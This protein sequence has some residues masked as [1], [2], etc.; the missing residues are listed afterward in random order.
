[1]YEVSYYTTIISM[2]I[3]LRLRVMTWSVCGF[4]K[5]HFQHVN[6]QQL[7][8]FLK[9]SIIVC[10]NNKLIFPLKILYI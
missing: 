5:I 9:V 7:V 10:K 8:L 6:N 2:Y 4:K 1:M 3:K